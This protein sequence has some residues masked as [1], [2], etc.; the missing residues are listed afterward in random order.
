[1]KLSCGLLLILQMLVGER[2][3]KKLKLEIYLYKNKKQGEEGAFCLVELICW[4]VRHFPL[5]LSFCGKFL[6][7]LASRKIK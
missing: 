7:V 1:M 3:E 5:C 2:R 4:D 6:V